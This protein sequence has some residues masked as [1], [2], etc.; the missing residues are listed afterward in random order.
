MFHTYAEFQLQGYV[1]RKVEL[2]NGK[3]LKISIAAT[4]V[5]KTWGCLCML[6][7]H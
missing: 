7:V 3:V 5:G 1:G 4:G 6:V 2:G